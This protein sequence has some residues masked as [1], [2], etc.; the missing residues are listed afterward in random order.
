MNLLANISEK[1]HEFLF[2]ENIELVFAKFLQKFIKIEN[3][4]CKFSW[5]TLLEI[6]KYFLNKLLQIVLV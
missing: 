6:R 5:K 2:S 3:K 1:C 4:E